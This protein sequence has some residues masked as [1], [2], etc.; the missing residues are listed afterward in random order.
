MGGD[1]VLGLLVH[2]VGSNL[3]LE[4][5]GRGADNRR[6]ER[7]VVIDLGHSD[8]VFKTTG[9]GMPQSMH[10]TKRGIAIAHRMG[11]DA[12]RHQIINL[13]ELLALA[14]H[15]LIDGPIVL[16]TTVDLKT[17]KANAVELIGKRLDS[18]G[19]KAFANLA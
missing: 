13:G 11:D 4:R 17:L 10:G 1:A 8:I 12:Q 7:L 2:L 14:L 9:H 5:T 18:L 16:G 15:L 19:Q 6:M 3:N